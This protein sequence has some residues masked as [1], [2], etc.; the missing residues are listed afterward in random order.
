VPFFL[1][2]GRPGLDNWNEFAFVGDAAGNLT[3][4]NYDSMGGEAQIALCPADAV[5]VSHD[6]L[7]ACRN[8]LKRSVYAPN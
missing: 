3:I 4:Y 2:A 1:C 6:G 8:Q 7:L 5:R